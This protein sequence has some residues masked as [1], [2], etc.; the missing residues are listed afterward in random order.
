MRGRVLG[1]VVPLSPQASG[2]VAGVEWYDGGIGF[3]IPWRDALASAERLKAGKDLVPGLMG[4]VLKSSDEEPGARPKVD[5]VRYGSPADKAGI[6]VGDVVEKI[7]G[8]PLRRPTDLQMATGTKYAGDVVSLEIR[9]VG[10]S[11]T[12]R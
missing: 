7:A 8:R 11:R 3:A 4:I 10:T 9:R 1:I 5:R 6:K 2:D 12:S